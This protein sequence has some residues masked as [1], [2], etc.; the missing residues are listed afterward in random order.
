[1]SH[2]MHLLGYLM[3]TSLKVN[4]AIVLLLNIIGDNAKEKRLIDSLKSDDAKLMLDFL[5][6]VSHSCLRSRV[7]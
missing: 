1:M 7:R 4:L 2:N 3:L 6:N 5:V